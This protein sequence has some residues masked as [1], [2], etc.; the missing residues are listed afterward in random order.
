[1][2]KLDLYWMSNP[3]WFDFA[4]DENAEPFLTDA[5]PTKAKESFKRFLEQ[6]KEM[7]NKY[8]AS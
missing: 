4:D 5:A 7:E 1:M 8:K 3:D 2:K 6:K